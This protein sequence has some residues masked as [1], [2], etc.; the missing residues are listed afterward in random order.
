MRPTE[1]WN[2]MR[3]IVRQQ[4]MIRLF[5]W[6][7]SYVDIDAAC[8]SPVKGNLLTHSGTL[9]KQNHTVA[10]FPKRFY[11]T[12]CRESDN[13]CEVHWDY[14]AGLHRPEGSG[15]VIL[16]TVGSAWP[17]W[18]GF[19]PCVSSHHLG[20]SD[21]IYPMNIPAHYVQF[22]CIKEN[23]NLC[24]FCRSRVYKGYK[25]NIWPLKNI[26]T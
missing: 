7:S 22:A 9:E 15:Q 21:L 24:F 3:P 17:L 20:K 19:L 8:P 12:T 18:G 23:P 2:E 4:T 13:A 1:R 6:S 5:Q 16:E 14:Q 10:V 26:Y 11:V 25:Q